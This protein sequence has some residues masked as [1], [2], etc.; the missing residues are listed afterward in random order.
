MTLGGGGHGCDTFAGKVRTRE[1]K[2]ARNGVG[3]FYTRRRSVSQVEKKR[4][5]VRPGE[6]CVGLEA[7]GA[8]GGG[9]RAA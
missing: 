9:A 4:K 8:S 2:E 6:R 1:E 5:G 3:G 7:T